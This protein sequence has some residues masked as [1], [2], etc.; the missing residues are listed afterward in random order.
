[1]NRVQMLYDVTLQLQHILDREI[2]VNNREQV[3]EQVNQLIEI[4]G[5]HMESLTSPYTDEEK[6][7]GK[8]IIIL[9]DKIE[10]KMHVLFNELK[11]EMK[12]VKKQ[13]QSNR[14][15]TNPYEHVQTMDGM[16]LDSKK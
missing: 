5:K 2:T 16:F 10:K 7:L 14:K 8:K 3:I 15:Y 1:M 4:R 9:N 12:E 11:T 6:M 13:K